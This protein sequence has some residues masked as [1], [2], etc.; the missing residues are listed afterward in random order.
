MAVD[1]Y[2]VKAPAPDGEVRETARPRKVPLQVRL[3]QY[4]WLMLLLLPGVIYFVVFKYMPMYGVTLAFKDYVPVLGWSDSPWV[5]LKHFDRMFT[6]PDFP[7][8]FWNTVVLAFL[9]VVIVFPMPIIVALMLNELRV[10]VLKRMIQTAIYIPHFLSWA[11]VASITFLLFA[12]GDGP[13][14][15][16]VERLTGDTESILTDP[17][18]FRPLIILQTLWKSVGWGT[19]IYLAALAGVDASLYEAA[20]ID[21]ATRMRQLWHVTLPA[22][23]STIIVML[24]LQ[25]GTLLDTGFEQIYLMTNS[26]NRGV[27]EVLDTYTYYMGIEQGAFSYSTAVGLFKGVI[28]AVL[29]FGTNFLAKKFNQSTLF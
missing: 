25:S 3:L 2:E 10:T 24:I 20:R 4:R 13:L 21:G 19:I 28:G 9:N 29:I 18:W 7:R 5:G 1:T 8:V 26:L 22:I 12:Y 16:L 11:I 23:R 6:S 27:A 17:A 15:L 14:T